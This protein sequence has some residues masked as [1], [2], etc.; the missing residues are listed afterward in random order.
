MKHVSIFTPMETEDKEKASELAAGSSKRPAEIELDH[1]IEEVY[2]EALQVKY[3]I[4][5]WE[6]Y[7]EDSREY[8]KIIRVGNYTEAYQTFAEI[9]KRFNRDDLEKIWDL[10]K[11][12]FSSTEPTDDKE[13]ELWVKLKRLFEPDNDDI[14]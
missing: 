7:T 10:V 2:I 8:W 6:V 13:K 12:R 4:I 1:E 3:P 9:L 14:L 11:K 5:D